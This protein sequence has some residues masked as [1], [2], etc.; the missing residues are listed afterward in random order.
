MANPIFLYNT[1][2]KAIILFISPWFLLYRGLYKVK[3]IAVPMP[4]SAKFKKLRILLNVDS[5]PIKSS[6]KSF[7]KILREKNWIKIE[8]VK[9][10]TPTFAFFK[11]LETRAIYV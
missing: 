3:P 2:N 7:K 4:S 5:R 11:D 6:P 1:P 8:M 9:K 10:N